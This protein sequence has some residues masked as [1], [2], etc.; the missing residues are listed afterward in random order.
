MSG[1]QTKSLTIKTHGKH[2]TAGVIFKPWGLYAAFG[3]DAKALVNNTIN[4]QVL[5]NLSYEVKNNKF[6]DVQFFD[7]L[8][9]YL[10]KEL[11]KSK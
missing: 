11:V 10:L 5:Y 2:I 8:E 4:S 6:S 1:L 9:Y 3:I 7:L